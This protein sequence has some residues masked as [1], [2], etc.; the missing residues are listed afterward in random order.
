[1]RISHYFLVLLPYLK[2]INHLKELPS[3]KTTVTLSAISTCFYWFLHMNN[4]SEKT[5]AIGIGTTRT[6]K[7]CECEVLNF[8][9]WAC[10]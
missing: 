3:F 4:E 7:I 9:F 8:V 6:G 5:T 10:K 1:M 2:S